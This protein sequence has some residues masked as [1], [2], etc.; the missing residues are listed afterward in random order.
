MP[1]SNPLSWIV[2]AHWPRS[3]QARPKLRYLSVGVGAVLL[4]TLLHAKTAWAD[5]TLHLEPIPDVG[6]F[7]APT[8]LIGVGLQPHHYD[9]V[10]YPE[11]YEGLLIVEQHPGAEPTTMLWGQRP[12]YLEA[13]FVNT[14]RDAVWLARSGVV[15]DVLPNGTAYEIPYGYGAVKQSRSILTL[16]EAQTQPHLSDNQKSYKVFPLTDI[17][18]GATLSLVGLRADLRYVHKERYVGHVQA[19]LN[20][21]GLAGA[22]VNRT[23]ESFAVPL[24]VGGG[25]RYPS[26]WSVIGNNWTTGAEAVLGLGSVDNDTDTANV[27]LLPGLFHEVEW[28]FQRDLEVMDHRGDP[29][30]Y[31]YGLHSFY[32]KVGAYADFIGGATTSV[33]LDVHVGY[34]FNIQ[35]PDIPT[36]AFKETKVTYASQR[37]VQRKLEEKQR[38]T[39]LQAAVES[40]PPHDGPVAPAGY[41]AATGPYPP[42]SAPPTAP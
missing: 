40:A 35:G 22:N 25:L 21:G 20:L 11:S 29:R 31:N 9:A 37:Y 5:P 3:S 17:Y 2:V 1:L 39:A 34:R 24:V 38:Q 15:I 4:F 7:V 12:H 36:H 33:V 30:P 10:G 14:Q 6:E 41:P 26:V 27:I 19:G 42:P 16:I 18:L 8:H 13:Q 28:T 23:Y 32:A